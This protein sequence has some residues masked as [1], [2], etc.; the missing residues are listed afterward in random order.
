MLFE[1]GTHCGV[2]II[3]SLLTFLKCSSSLAVYKRNRLDP[4]SF[5]WPVEGVSEGKDEDND[6]Y[7]EGDGGAAHQ[8]RAHSLL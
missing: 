5:V 1:Y 6:E 3:I 4:K 2:S 7:D 8:D